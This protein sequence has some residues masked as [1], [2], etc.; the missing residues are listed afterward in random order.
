MLFRSSPK[1]VDPLF[2]IE[3][4]REVVIRIKSGD[5]YLPGAKKALNGIHGHIVY[6]N[7][8]SMYGVK[9]PGKAYLVRFKKPV[10]AWWPNGDPLREF[11][12]SPADIR[13]T[14]G[15]LKK[16]WKEHKVKGG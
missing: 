8:T 9:C 15:G 7:L 14:R 2:P 4:G 12:L 10:K 5:K 11:W 6:C 3:G 16:W 13:K 1:T